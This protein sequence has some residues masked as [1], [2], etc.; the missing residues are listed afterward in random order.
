MSFWRE[1]ASTTG[2]SENVVVKEKNSSNV[3]SFIILRSGEGLFFPFIFHPA[4]PIYELISYI[5]ISKNNHAYFSGK[6]KSTLNWAFP[7]AN[8]LFLEK[9]LQVKFCPRSRPRPTI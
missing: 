3:R 9:T 4:A 6:K 7:G 5:S 2:F 8:R 1:N